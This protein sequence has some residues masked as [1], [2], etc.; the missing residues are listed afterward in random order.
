MSAAAAVSV[1]SDC[2]TAPVG[3]G[4]SSTGEEISSQLQ[5]LHREQE[6]LIADCE[7]I[8]ES[9]MPM[10]DAG[11]EALFGMSKKDIMEVKALS[12]PPPA[13]GLVME[14]VA[15]LLDLKPIKAADPN[16]PGK[17]VSDYAVPMKKLLGGNF[18]EEIAQFDKDSLSDQKIAQLQAY[19][20]DPSLQPDVQRKISPLG[21][22]LSVWL[23][24]IV[25]YAQ[26]S[27]ALGPK[28]ERLKQVAE[29]MAILQALTPT[30]SSKRHVQRVGGDIEERW[31]AF[32]QRVQAVA[33]D[34][35][36]SMRTSLDKE[37]DILSSPV[38]ELQ[39]IDQSL[40]DAVADFA[41]MDTAARLK[42]LAFLLAEWCAWGGV[43]PQQM[44]EGE[45]PG[46]GKT[47]EDGA[48]YD[49]PLGN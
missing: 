4:G 34:V 6:E 21:H 31:A 37:E 10:L 1:S 8:L 45:H 13:L 48:E 26:A 9:V 32:Q 17:K 44:P 18:L 24:S 36:A 19:L 15:V 43:W 39:G 25:M 2:P 22:A 7:R 5:L 35:M 28:R 49:H 27:K 41:V 23:R 12:K 30:S 46:M 20:Q 38:V 16:D 11:T 14:A 29:E 3:A 47:D 33:V 42:A 40:A